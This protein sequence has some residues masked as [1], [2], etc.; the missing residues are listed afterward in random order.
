MQGC[1]KDT[2]LPYR[3]HLV[4][5]L[6][7]LIRLRPGLAQDMDSGAGLD[8]IKIKRL[9][10]PQLPATVDQIDELGVRDGLLQ[11]AGDQLLEVGDAAPAQGA[12]PEL[13]LG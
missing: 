11:L 13:R 3:C 10:I 12:L 9:V 7:F 4:H 5:W 6:W 2:E 8:A 1:V